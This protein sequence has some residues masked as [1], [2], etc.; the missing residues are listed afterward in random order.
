MF[1][2]TLPSAAQRTKPVHSPDLRLCR[3]CARPHEEFP[4]YG[5]LKEESGSLTTYCLCWQSSVW[6]T[7][8]RV[9]SMTKCRCGRRQNPRL[10]ELCTKMGSRKWRWVWGCGYITVFVMEGNLRAG[11]ILSWHHGAEVCRQTCLV[12]L[13]LAWHC[14]LP[15]QV[16]PNVFSLLVELPPSLKAEI[17]RYS[18]LDSP[19]TKV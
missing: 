12:T 4:S 7:F 9:D 5:R 18:L 17:A 6:V 8:K 15:T 19:A 14:W 2:I 10:R 3:P 16:I 13:C 1:S 11:R